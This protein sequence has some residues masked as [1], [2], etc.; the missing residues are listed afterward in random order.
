MYIAL[1]AFSDTIPVII[2]II[3]SS[4]SFQIAEILS[5]LKGLIVR[6]T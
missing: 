1:L 3:S 6:K 5:L 2:I 4:S